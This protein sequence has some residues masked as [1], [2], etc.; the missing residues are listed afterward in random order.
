MQLQQQI[1]YF[2][3]LRRDWEGFLARCREIEKAGRRPVALGVVGIKQKVR[4]TS[5][6][7]M[8]SDP[9]EHCVVLERERMGMLVGEDEPL[10]AY[11][12]IQREHGK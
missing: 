3:A 11:S 5:T 6:D 2:A 8:T 10:S 12:H 1:E 9:V 7:T 4:A